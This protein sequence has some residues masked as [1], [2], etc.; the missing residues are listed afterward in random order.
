MKTSRN[1]DTIHPPLAAY[2]HQVEITG[3]ERLLV[4]SGQIGMRTDGSVPSDPID[5]VQLA[6]D[7]LVANLAAAQMSTADI[8][9]LTIYLVGEMSGP[10][11]RE[12]IAKHL[13]GHKPC[14]TLVYVTALASPEYRVEIDAWASRSS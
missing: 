1:P 14:M 7:N 5:Q 4:L 9:K 3:N 11:R 13:G 6:L 2:S 10:L 12:A 8:V